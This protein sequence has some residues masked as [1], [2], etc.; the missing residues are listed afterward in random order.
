VNSVKQIKLIQKALEMKKGKHESDL[1][2]VNQVLAR[3]AAMLMQM[4]NYRK[5]YESHQDNRN[6]RKIPSLAENWL[7]FVKKI[8]DMIIKEKQEMTRLDKIKNGIIAKLAECQNLISHFAKRAVSLV[9]KQEY[10]KLKKEEV[11][12][13]DLAVARIIRKDK[14]A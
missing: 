14:N 3:K 9:E 7:R 2:Q 13:A 12:T 8:D 5:E 1:A 11:N 6:Y 10:E 4:E